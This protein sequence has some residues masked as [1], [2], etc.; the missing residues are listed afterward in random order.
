MPFAIQNTKTKKFVTGTDYRYSPARQFTHKDIG[1]LWGNKTFCEMNYIHR[2]CGKTYEVVEVKPIERTSE[3][4]IG[5]DEI[6]E[7]FEMD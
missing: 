5:H 7:S 6:Y 1:L 2:Q 4:G 3:K